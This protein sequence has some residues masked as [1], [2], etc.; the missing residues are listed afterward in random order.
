M[1]YVF[2]A[3]LAYAGYATGYVTTGYNETEGEGLLL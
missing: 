1:A 3:A 2:F